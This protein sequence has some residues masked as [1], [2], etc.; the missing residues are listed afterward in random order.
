MP[1]C[2]YAAAS[3]LGERDVRVC[4]CVHAHM[5]IINFSSVHTSYVRRLSARPS[6]RALESE[7]RREKHY[8]RYFP[9]QKNSSSESSRSLAESMRKGAFTRS[10][11]IRAR[12]RSTRAMRANVYRMSWKSRTFSARQTLEARL[13]I[14]FPQPRVNNIFFFIA[15]RKLDFREL[16]FGEICETSNN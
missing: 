7:N 2:N 11:A 9:E 16:N 3:I 10:D 13:A 6:A 1:I 14:L 5:H 15:N 4:M 8:S 12:S